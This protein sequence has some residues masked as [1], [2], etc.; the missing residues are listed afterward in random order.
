M[1]RKNSKYVANISL[2][3]MAIGFLATLPFE[4]RIVLKLLQGGF[5]AGLVG[6]LADWFAVTALFRHPLGLPIPHTALLPK[7][8]EKITETIL[9]IVE[10]D[11]LKKESIMEKIGRINIS[12]ILVKKMEEELEKEGTRSQLETFFK[13]MI[14]SV[15][16]EKIHAATD[17][18]M[19]EGIKNIPTK[20]VLS[21][22]I[23]MIKREK[24]E[25][26]TFDLVVEII[27]KKVSEQETK[28]RIVQFVMATMA[29]KAK[30]SLFSV[31]LTPMLNMGKEKVAE[32]VDKAMNDFIDDL[33][34]KNGTNRRQI[35][36]YIGYELENIKESHTVHKRI[37]EKRNLFLKS[38]TYDGLSLKLAEILQKKMNDVINEE[39]FF[40]EKVFPIIEKVIGKVKND[41]E[42]IEKMEQK[43]KENLAGFIENNHSRIG[44]L[45]RDNISKLKNE[46]LIDMMENKIGKELAWI[47]VNG[48]LCGFMIGIILTII[49]ITY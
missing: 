40:N 31:I 45:V 7:N 3:I 29:K 15:T 37:E 5:E 39:H 6:G 17:K 48:A 35:L 33:K 21:S 46:E 19:T 25:E 34:D 27:E 14:Q 36:A 18:L 16:V 41:P 1:K 28:E 8:R 42:A 30:T 12:S 22:S 24:Y 13:K 4:E 11:W 49:K 32:T 10:N 2:L 44:S 26:K 20:K 47:R 9:Q 23:D 43:L 38:D